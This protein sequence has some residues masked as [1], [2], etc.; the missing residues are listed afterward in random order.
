MITR[1][2]VGASE[3]LDVLAPYKASLSIYL[4]KRFNVFDKR[5]DHCA[6]KHS[7]TN[8]NIVRASKN[9]RNISHIAFKLQ[10]RKELFKF[11]QK[12]IDKEVLC[13]YVFYEWDDKWV[14]SGT[15]GTVTLRLIVSQEQLHGEGSASRVLDCRQK[16][17]CLKMDKTAYVVDVIETA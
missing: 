11:K 12:L 2:K 9:F 7:I 13:I 14:P 1:L 16:Q 5:K 10:D 17:I 6:S 8:K 4:S 15:Q 3:S